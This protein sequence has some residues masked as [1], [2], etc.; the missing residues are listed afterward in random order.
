[1]SFNDLAQNENAG[2]WPNF[3][4]TSIRCAEF[5]LL[6][7]FYSSYP[8]PMA[9][10]SVDPSALTYLQDNTFSQGNYNWGDTRPFV[11]T[12]TFTNPIELKSFIVGS[13]DGQPNNSAPGFPSKDILFEYSTDGTNFK[14]HS[15]LV[16][17]DISSGDSGTSTYNTLGT[18]PWNNTNLG[19][20]SGNYQ[21]DE[22]R[23]DGSKWY[24]FK[25]Y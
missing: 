13:T 25:T 22:F 8:T 18:Y 2:A 14:V 23:W 1:M 6:D 15:T 17:K 4:T 10:D 9:Y 3:T 16:M 7:D 24:Y 5:S 19:P 20:F 12:I 11:Y 21:K